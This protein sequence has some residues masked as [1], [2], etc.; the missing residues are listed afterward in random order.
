MSEDQPASSSS[1]LSM[2]AIQATTE[3]VASFVQWIAEL[4]Q[5]RNW[6]TLLLLVDVVLFFALKPQGGILIG[7]LQQYFDLRVPNWYH[8]NFWIL[9][10]SIFLAA[11]AVAVKTM[12]R[13]VSLEVQ[14]G[15]ERKVI[16]GLRAFTLE[17]ADVF[18]QLQRGQSIET[19]LECLRELHKIIDPGIIGETFS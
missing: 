17:D 16:K 11:I 9:L 12:P 13:A 18:A 8:G 15:S 6:F 5:K 2:G 7:F 10:G 14:E 3:K 1:S 4:I 19:C